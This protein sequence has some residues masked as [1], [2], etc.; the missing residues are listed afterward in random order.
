MRLLHTERLDFQEFF[1]SQTPKYAILSHRWTDDEVSFQDFDR[2]KA[3]QRPSF[4]KISNCCSLA[5]KNG[6]EWVWIDT[7]CIDKKSSAELSEA[8][9]SMYAWYQ[10]AGIC[11]AYLADVLLIEDEYGNLED[12]RAQFHRSAWFTRGWTLQ[13]LLAPG[14]VEFFDHAWLSIGHKG[15]SSTAGRSLSRDISDVTGISEDNLRRPPTSQCIA[16]K[17]SWISKRNTTRVEDM[18]YCMLGLCGVN[19]PLLYGE[20]EKAFLRLQSEIIKQ[21]DDES[22]FAWFCDREGRSTSFMSGLIAPSPRC[23]AESG[24]V[25]KG[26]VLSKKQPY[27][28][29]NK[30]LAY[31]IPRPSNWTEEEPAQGDHYSLCLGCAVGFGDET[32]KS[33][34]S[35]LLEFRLVT[36]DLVFHSNSWRRLQLRIKP[37]I[38]SDHMVWDSVTA[39][40]DSFFDTIYFRDAVV[41]PRE[42]DDKKFARHFQIPEGQTWTEPSGKEYQIRDWDWRK[43]ETV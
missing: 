27:S 12:S 38:L 13:E 17:L 15:K 8:I 3:E 33:S 10:K 25:V 29:T 24:Q 42:I 5:K 22:I 36:I 32:L 9:N 16:K 39:D 6:Y 1:D 40:K 23:F 19:M 37:I 14:I 41:E 2:C 18:A 31:P 7:C 28:Q 20:G 11:Y 26:S 35:L 43:D 34:N 30:G 4:D 21:S